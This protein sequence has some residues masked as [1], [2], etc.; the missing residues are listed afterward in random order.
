MKNEWVDND[1]C[2]HFVCSHAPAN[3]LTPSTPTRSPADEQA[4]DRTL[5]IAHTMTRLILLI[6][7][8]NISLVYTQNITII[9]LNVLNQFMNATGFTDP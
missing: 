8:V 3:V 1:T 6:F 5:S 2:H 7:I 9:E 4:A